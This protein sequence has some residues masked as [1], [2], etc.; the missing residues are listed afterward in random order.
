MDRVGN[1]SSRSSIR[2]SSHS[3]GDVKRV[4]LGQTVWKPLFQRRHQL[5]D[6]PSSHP[7]VTQFIRNTHQVHI[8]QAVEVPGALARRGADRQNPGLRPFVG[9]ANIVTASQLQ[10]MAQSVTT[11]SSVRRLY[12]NH[13]SLGL[14]AVIPVSIASGGMVPKARSP[15]R[16]GTYAKAQSRKEM[17]GRDET[18]WRRTRRKNYVMLPSFAPG[19]W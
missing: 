1:R 13:R 12:W 3:T 19:L 10:R 7:R 18:C 17:T 14:G 11:T 9:S 2:S 15:F 5:P 16:S 8:L 6:R 4:H